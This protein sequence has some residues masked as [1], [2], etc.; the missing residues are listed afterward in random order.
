MLDKMTLQQIYLEF[1][2]FSP[3]NQHSII[4]PNALPLRYA[5]ALTR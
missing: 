4:V 3:A 5:K 2:W 1:L